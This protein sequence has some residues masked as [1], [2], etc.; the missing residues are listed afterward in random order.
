MTQGHTNNRDSSP[1]SDTR[2]YPWMGRQEPPAQLKGFPNSGQPAL[3]ILSLGQASNWVTQSG[4]IQ[5]ERSCA[6]LIHSRAFGSHQP[7]EDWNPWHYASLLSKPRVRNLTHVFVEWLQ[8]YE[9][10]QILSILIP[11]HLE[12]GSG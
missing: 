10:V 6:L 5:A 11:T 2:L 7:A 4:N 8:H 3:L 12:M 9:V 1:C